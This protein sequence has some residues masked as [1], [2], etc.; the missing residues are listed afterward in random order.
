MLLDAAL[1]NTQVFYILNDS[2]VKLF[3]KNVINQ[4]PQITNKAKKVMKE[5]K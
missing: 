3:Y 5:F 2:D 1:N 4:M